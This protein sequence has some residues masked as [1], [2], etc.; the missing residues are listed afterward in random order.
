M[1]RLSAPGAFVL[2]ASDKHRSGAGM[3]YAVAVRALCE[4]TA[5]QGDL[6]LR[7]TP[8]PTAQQGIAG[9]ALVASRRGNGYQREISLAG[10]YQELRVRGRADG[11]DALKN[12]LE[13]VKTFRGDLARLPENHRLLHWAQV[14]IYGWLLCQE[15]GL[16]EVR[17]AL[18]YFDIGS[19]RE[20]LLSELYTADALRQFFEAHC[21]RFLVWARQELAHRAARDAGLRTLAFPHADFRAGQRELAESVY[22]AASGG[23]CLMAQAP[24]GIGKTIGTVFPLLKAMPRRELDKV[25]FLAAKTSG[26]ALAIE[27]LALLRE[28]APPLA[29][30][31]VE[32]VARDKACEHPDKTCHGESCPLARG[33]YDRLPA[34]RRAAFSGMPKAGLLERETVRGIALAHQ[35]CPYYLSQELV[36]WTDVVVGD[37]N[38]YFDVSALLHALTVANQWRV[39]VLVDEA[40]NL[41]ERGRKMYSAELDPAALAALRR[42]PPAT[43]VKP[44]ERLH[45]AWRALRNNPHQDADVDYLVLDNIS[46]KF[47]LVLQQAASAIAEE[48][49]AN[50]SPA[51]AA[52]QRFYFDALHFSRLAENFG[53]HS[54]FDMTREEHA[55]RG[56]FRLCVRNVVP[57]PFL[58]LRFAAAQSVTLFSATLSPRGF[59][60]DMLGLPADTA[61]IDVRSPF[62][63]GQLSVRVVSDISTRYQH[64]ER[65]LAPIVDLMAW[66][67]ALKP[68]NYLVF[69]SSYDYLEKLAALFTACHPDIGVWR[70]TRGMDEA[71]RDR[72]LARFGTS[73]RGFGFAVLGGAFAEG[74][75]LPGDRL[76]GAFIATLGLPQI[77]AVNE[78]IRQRIGEIFGAAAAYDYSYLFPG[79]QKV[80]QAAGRVIRSTSDCG[81]IYLMDDRFARPEVN[82]LMPLWWRIGRVRLGDGHRPAGQNSKHAEQHQHQDDGNRNT[83]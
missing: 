30:R 40:H 48:F 7:F 66:Q 16:R 64:R 24:T 62:D 55:G 28:S 29:L 82:A 70:Q 76:I 60:A 23:R 58:K 5:K 11:Y 17:L 81:V 9:H 50:P 25:F 1:A 15:R 36:R 14:K 44:L 26:R 41:V 78:R 68:G 42:S 69:L 20:T 35:V 79:L 34:A 38:Y 75:D 2:H 49:E 67:Y 61:W 53:E 52:L 57:A 22:K 19:Q 13:E 73:T 12:Q 6:D 27:A 21:E 37:Y 74:I 32:L 18:V 46:D 10:D 31:V 54:L 33:F 8:S 47:L 77:N 43:L 63:A 4:F 65:S 83:E 71:A 3:S 72:F 59:Y 51:D 80:V 56:L 45:R 39:G